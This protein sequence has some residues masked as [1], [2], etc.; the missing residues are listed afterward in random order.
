MAGSLSGLGET[1][2]VG[3]HLEPGAAGRGVHLQS[4][5]EAGQGG[6]SRVV[7]TMIGAQRSR[8][9]GVRA[10][11]VVV[12]LLERLSVEVEVGPDVLHFERLQ[13][14]MIQ[15]EVLVMIWSAVK[16]CVVLT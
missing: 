13:S 2:L 16:L 1:F 12:I 15:A 8:L 6:G 3:R 7:E 5:L 4:C 10:P 9:V 14:V 11:A